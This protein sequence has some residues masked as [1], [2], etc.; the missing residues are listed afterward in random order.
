M[1]ATDRQADRLLVADLVGLLNDAEHYSGPGSSSYSRLDYLE[2]RAGLLH[3]LVDAVG[4]ES[5]RYL[6]QDAEDRT[7]DLRARAEALARECGDPWPARST[8]SGDTNGSAPPIGHAGVDQATTVPPHFRRRE[9]IAAPT[10]TPAP[11]PPD[12]RTLPPAH[13]W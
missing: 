12:Q 1:T 7:E 8:D 3:R 4:D 9:E 2:R 11:H 5:S 10:P 6:A 13:T